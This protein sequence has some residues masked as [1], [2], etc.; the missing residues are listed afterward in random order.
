[1]LASAWLGLISAAV[2]VAPRLLQTQAPLLNWHA[3]VLILGVT[4]F[5]VAIQRFVL[6]RRTGSRAYDGLADLFIHI[7]TPSQLDS[8][9]RWG[10]RGV[11]SWL[12]NLFGGSVGPEGA[13]V[14]LSHALALRTRARS[15]K[16]FEQRRRTDASSAL[17]AGIAAAFGAPFAGFLLPIE[18]GIGG[19]AL[20]SVISAIVAFLGARLMIGAFG[21]SVVDLG[22]AL[23]GFKFTQGREIAALIAISLSAAVVGAFSIKVI[24]YCQDSLLDLFQTRAWMRILAGGVLLFLV[25]M[26]HPA[27]HLNPVSL[28]EQTIWAQKS[29]SSVG[30]LFCVELLSL[31]LVLAAF[32]SVGL[33]WPLFAIGSFL[34]AIVTQLTWMGAS[35]MPIGGFVAISGLMGAASLWGAVLGAPLTGAVVVYE[36]TQSLPA[37]LAC[38]IG[39]WVARDLRQLMHR[40]SLI[41][42]DLESRGLALIE[43]RSAAVLDAVSVKDAMVADHEIVHEQEPVSELYSRLLKS[44]YPFLP[45]VST[46]GMFR[47]LLTADMVQE[48]WQ[49]QAAV[50]SNSP[51]AKLL[52]AKDLLYRS[53]FRTPTV[54][55]NDKLSAAARL[56]ED[57]PCI[58]VLGDDSRVLGLLFAYNVRLAYDREVARRSLSFETREA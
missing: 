28:V 32:G 26:I 40:G 58:P 39:A 55:A 29:L 14:E 23:H 19:R 3:P 6:D 5:A 37:F 44:R 27:G 9:G 20:S 22:S 46:Q 7:H 30:L 11:I 18:L 25:A 16:W 17:S 34:G 15:S 57:L 21:L 48:G 1:M 49:S 12:L 43:G 50:T 33:F 4:S 42:R 52:E 41:D 38:L 10:L 31:G 8:P 54:K 56:F 13:A 53:G 51:L 35:V 45:V 47:G 2:V 24:R 36:M